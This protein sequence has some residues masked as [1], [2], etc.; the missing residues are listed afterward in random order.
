MFIEEI[1]FIIIIFNIAVTIV[2]IVIST[3]AEQPAFV[4]LAFR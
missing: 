2:I 3:A 1:R 4:I